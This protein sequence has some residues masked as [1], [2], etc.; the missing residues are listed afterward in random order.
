MLRAIAHRDN[1]SIKSFLARCSWA[2][3]VPSADP[4]MLDISSWRYPS[5][6]W[7]TKTVRAPGG[8]FAIARSR[9]TRDSVSTGSVIPAVLGASRRS[10]SSRSCSAASSSARTT[11]ARRRRS[12][13]ASISTSLTAIRCNHE[14][15]C[16]SPRKDASRSQAR[17]N[18]L[19]VS[20]RARCPIRRHA[21]AERI[22]R[23]PPRAGRPAR[24]R[25]RRR[26]AHDRPAAHP[27][28]GPDPRSQVEPRSSVRS[29]ASGQ[30][31]LASRVLDAA[32]GVAA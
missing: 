17:T 3:D 18:T 6:S 10:S 19:C 2:L 28:R 32:R 14:E 12:V 1:A 24:T 7:S 5:I 25:R 13:L 4:V 29:I 30:G 20:S 21:Q 11:R 26:P 15:S 9:S 23:D 8:S 22:A 31:S 27:P 16:E